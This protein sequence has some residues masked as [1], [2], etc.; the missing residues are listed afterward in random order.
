MQW[1]GPT[2]P[3]RGRRSRINLIGLT[4]K[5]RKKVKHW[6]AHTDTDTT[7]KD[8]TGMRIHLADATPSI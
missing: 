4:N 3:S 1:V 8:T 2:Y 6:Q 5:E 7:N